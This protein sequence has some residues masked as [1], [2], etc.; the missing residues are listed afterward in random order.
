MNIT[1]EYIKKSSMIIARDPG[2]KLIYKSCKWWNKTAVKNSIILDCFKKDVK[3]NEIIDINEQIA[4]FITVATIR[5]G[6]G[7]YQYRW[8]RC[9]QKQY[10]GLIYEFMI[11]NGKLGNIKLNA[12]VGCIRSHNVKLMMVNKSSLLSRSK[13]NFIKEEIKEKLY[14]SINE[15]VNI[16]IPSKNISIKRLKYLKIYNKKIN[17]FNKIKTK[18][19]QIY[20]LT[21]KNIF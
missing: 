8:R 3:H 16:N 20:H 4:H 14:K 7:C 21:L 1:F 10:K 12:I 2:G 6:A 15:K 19:L 17:L 11:M 13:T 9:G 18:T 5:L